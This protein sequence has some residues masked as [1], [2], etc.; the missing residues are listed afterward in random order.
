M[1][2]L[3][4]ATVLTLATTSSAFCTLT[5]KTTYP[6]YFGDRRPHGLGAELR[7]F[8]VSPYKAVE[9]ARIERVLQVIDSLTIYSRVSE[10]LF[11]ERV[12]FSWV[13]SVPLKA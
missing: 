10:K 5:I 1:L 13:P 6:K 11:S 7:L 4:A 8:D 12:G 9:Q 2:F 3:L